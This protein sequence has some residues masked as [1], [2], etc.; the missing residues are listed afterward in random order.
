VIFYTSVYSLFTPFGKIAK[1]FTIPLR[2]WHRGDSSGK[3]GDD[4]TGNVWDMDN[5]ERGRRIRTRFGGNLPFGYPVLSGYSNGNALIIR[6]MDLNKDTWYEPSEVLSH[7]QMDIEELIRF[8]GTA[9][10]WG[11]DSIRICP[12]DIRQRFFKLV[13]P[14]NAEQDRYH[15]VFA[16]LGSYCNGNGVIFEICRYQKSDNQKQ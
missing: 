5:F 7:L 6:S 16:A 13:I 9:L 2:T 4:P 14:E 10:P 8:D 3:L 15:S 12:G 11:K 1:S